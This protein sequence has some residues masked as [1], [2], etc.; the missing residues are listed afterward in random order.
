M[1]CLKNFLDNGATT[2]NS[3]IINLINTVLNIIIMAS[4]FIMLDN[5]GIKLK[6]KSFFI[7]IHSIV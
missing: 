3:A 4:L 5:G 6:K 7:S 2:I 1:L